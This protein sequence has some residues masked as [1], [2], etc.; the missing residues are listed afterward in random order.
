M[1]TRFCLWII[2]ARAITFYW[3]FIVLLFIPKT[4]YLQTNSKFIRSIISKCLVDIALNI[5][6]AS[7]I[8][9]ELRLIIR[10][11]SNYFDAHAETHNNT[12]TRK[13]QHKCTFIKIVTPYYSIIQ[14][15]SLFLMSNRVFI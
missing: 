4:R 12:F 10:D 3:V 14:L 13:H 8:Q 1:T 15:K 7:I 11:I 5:I 9:L 6:S 2:T